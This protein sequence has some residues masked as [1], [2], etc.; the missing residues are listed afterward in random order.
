[1]ASRTLYAGQAVTITTS[2]KTGI[3]P[4]QSA[5]LE[6][7]RPIE[8][9]SILGHINNVA[10]AQ[11]NFTT[12]KS[13]IKLYLQSGNTLGTASQGAIK[14][15]S[16]SGAPFDS[17][18]IKSL[19][20]DATTGKLTEI[21]VSPN[22]F[23]M[24]GIISNLGID[25]A[26][27]SFGMADLTFNGIGEPYFDSGTAGTTF[28]EPVNTTDSLAPTAITPVTSSNV[29]LSTNIGCSSSF[30]FSL[31]LP[32]EPLACLG[33]SVTGTQGS[34]SSSTMVIKYPLKASIALEGFG[35]DI[36]TNNEPALQTAMTGNFVV[37]AL[38]I[39]LPNPKILNKSFNQAV[40]NVGATFN[41]SAEDVNAE[42][43]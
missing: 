15:S 23:T 5:S 39:R 14:N 13:S 25:I 31:D 26:M 29:I 4:V 20:G 10:A 9:I 33:D 36:S 1:M 6:V 34:F 7:S 28:S 38:K 17:A 40:G 18:F 27:G 42:F 2:T 8:F 35:I 12:S 3:F 11:N 21:R 41:I 16:F 22:G 32:S 24:S 30:K 37:G 43:S 19:T